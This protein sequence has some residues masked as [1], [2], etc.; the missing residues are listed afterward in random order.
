MY[1]TGL[2]LLLC[3]LEP[4]QRSVPPP[5]F[6]G[7]DYQSA[8]TRQ[9]SPTVLA[10]WIKRVAPDS[11]RTDVIVLWRGEPGWHLTGSR[12]GVSSSAARDTHYTS[13]SYGGLE[14]EMSYNRKRQVVTIGGRKVDLKPNLNVVL[15]DR[16]GA[17]PAK[18]KIETLAVDES[19]PRHGPQLERVLGGSSRIVEF[20]Q[21]H[22]SLP[23]SRGKQMIERVCAQIT[24]K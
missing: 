17:D 22:L 3:A 13:I 7:R 21:C 18:F 24:G 12:R 16:V 23:D 15:V 8:E 1:K 9:V 19:L 14:L 4:S 10:T 2:L 5:G 6:E 20:L 11:E